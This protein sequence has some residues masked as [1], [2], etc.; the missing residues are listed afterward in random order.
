M[1]DALRRGEAYRKAGADLLLLSPRNAEE[2][3]HVAEHL[4][5]PLMLL[6]KPGGLANF[7]MSLEDMGSLGYRLLADPAT[8]LTAAYEAM[9]AV[10]TEM[11]DGFTMTSRPTADWGGLQDDMHDTIGLEEL[12]AVERRTVETE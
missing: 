7:D 11:A 1:D 12:L 8:P 6:L 5:G 3:R 4:G 9:R 10:Y 2:V